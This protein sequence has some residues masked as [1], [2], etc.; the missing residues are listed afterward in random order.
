MSNVY[1]GS[2]GANYCKKFIYINY[3]A[4]VRQLLK[5]PKQIYLLSFVVVCCR[6][7][8][9]R[10]Q[11]VGDVQ[12]CDGATNDKRTRGTGASDGRARLGVA[13]QKSQKIGT[14]FWKRQPHPLKKYRLPAEGS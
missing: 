1:G 7:S 14:D 4:C 6:I 3:G 13:P 11:G 9:A 8:V 2:R 12:G 10:V 5:L